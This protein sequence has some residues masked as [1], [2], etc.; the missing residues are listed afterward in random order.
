[1]TV[2]TR[3]LFRPLAPG[4]RAWLARIALSAALAV[5]SL[6]SA[7]SAQRAGTPLMMASVGDDAAV[8]SAFRA[9]LEDVI[10]DSADKICL[11]IADSRSAEDSDPSPGVLRA[12]RGATETTVL[13]RSACV[14]DERNFGNP[15]GLLRL[16]DVSRADPR[17]L[18]AHADAVGDHTAHYECSIPY[19]ATPSTRSQCRMTSRE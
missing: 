10:G 3:L 11:S 9:L 1:M 14:A 17:T 7:C 2:V 4:R 13:P 5:V 16:R 18:V 8:A 15:R 6:A 19:P 12:L